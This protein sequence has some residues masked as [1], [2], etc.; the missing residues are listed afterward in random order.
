MPPFA[1]LAVLLINVVSGLA[2]PTKV[3]FDLQVRAVVVS[4]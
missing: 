3:P 2:L 1:V 4:M